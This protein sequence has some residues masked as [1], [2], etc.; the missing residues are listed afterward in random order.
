MR[1][2]LGQG[3]KG[4]VWVTLREERPTYAQTNVA[5]RTATRRWP[6]L[7]VADWNAYSSGKPW[8]S[9]DGLHMGAAGAQGLARFLRP[10]V[11]CAVGLRA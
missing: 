11:I 7:K 5:I 10:Y 4:V 1:A 9:S 3:A 8:S 2:A 6:Q